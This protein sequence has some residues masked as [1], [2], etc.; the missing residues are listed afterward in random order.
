M[1]LLVGADA[2][3]VLDARCH[4]GQQLLTHAV[5]HR[6]SLQRLLYLDQ[7]GWEIRPLQTPPPHVVNCD[8]ATRRGLLQVV[9]YRAWVLGATCDQVG[10]CTWTNVALSHQTLGKRS[11]YDFKSGLFGWDL[12]QWRSDRRYPVGPGSPARLAS[13]CFAPVIWHICNW[14]APYPA[15]PLS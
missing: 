1:A 9:H 4:F 3:R 8:F 15:Y 13:G 10:K 12:C 5:A 7:A 6:A 11:A 2:P 14:K